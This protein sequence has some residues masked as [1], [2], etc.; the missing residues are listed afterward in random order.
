MIQQALQY[1]D[2][3]F[4]Q[5]IKNKFGSDDN[6]VLLNKIID[7]NGAVP[8]ENQN[9]IIISLIHVEEETVKQFY[10]RAQKTPQGNYINQ[11]PPQRYNLFLL[12]TPNFDD[13][14]ETLKFLNA[15]IQFF[16]DPSG[17]ECNK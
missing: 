9:K 7:Q 6:M 3:A 12:V 1:T 16:S 5:F 2:Q 13:Y 17:I 4:N 14:M 11:Y 10:N 8:P 15:A